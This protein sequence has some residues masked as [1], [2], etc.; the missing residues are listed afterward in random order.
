M[1]PDE[2][3]HFVERFDAMF[4]T[5]DINIADEIFTPNFRTD[6]PM[7]LEFKDLASFKSF[8]QGFYVSFPDMRQETYD[9]ILTA[10]KFVLRVCYFGTHKGDFMGVP[11]T[12]RK[13]VMPGMG[14]FRFEGTKAAE[15]WAMYDI[16]SV[17]QQVTAP[18]K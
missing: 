7:G 14:I 10:D 12:G 16:F 2:L 11:A 3:K 4:N 15:N 6:Q 18:A 1:T 5:P 8:V 9:S 17:Y 13:V